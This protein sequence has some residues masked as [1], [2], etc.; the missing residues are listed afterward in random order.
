M[1]GKIQACFFFCLLVLIAGIHH[2]L[3]Q[4]TLGIL[5]TNKQILLYWPSNYT[6][7][8][9][10][11][12]IDF[13]NWASADD[14][15]PASYGLQTAFSVS[16]S[17]STRFFRLIEP[18]STLPAVGMVQIPASS[19]TMG[20]ALDGQS[21]A[22]RTNI[23]VS[24]FFMETNLVTYSL[25]QTVYAYATGHGYQ[26]DYSGSGKA[27]NHPVQSVDWYSCVK[28]C[29]A[30]SQ[31]A[32]LT[33]VYFT[34]AGLT[35]VYAS[36]KVEPYINW[37]ANGYRLPTEA[38][39]EKAARGGLNGQRFPW[40]NNIS[41][42]LANYSGNTGYAYDSG[43]NG[44]NPTY[45]IGD[46]PYTSPVGSFA[47]N[48]YGLYDMAGNVFEWCWDRYGTAYGQP[49]TNNPTG[50]SSGSFRVL[51]GGSWAFDANAAR[52][53]YRF[54]DNPVYAGVFYGFRCV[55]GF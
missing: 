48:G 47:P 32:G 50:P 22:S 15:L 10:Q 7:C 49:S 4:P 36:G 5:S 25:W 16:N 46:N 26:F 9:L 19:Y 54:S 42:S 23:F 30:R 8:V 45:A 40:G 43:P 29:N 28:W 37:N 31:Q 18:A 44:F 20:D 21:D 12:S 38:E 51:R 1:K 27:T 14:A 3:A 2:L 55:K 53:A 52:C 33:P 39:W 35:Q 17:G 34:D 6:T 24:A 41:E 13:S 11:S